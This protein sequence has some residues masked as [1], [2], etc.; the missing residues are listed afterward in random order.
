MS[1]AGVSKRI[2]RRLRKRGT[3]FQALRQPAPEACRAVIPRAALLSGPST[4]LRMN[5]A[6]NLA[7]LRRLRLGELPHKLGHILEIAA[8]GMPKRLFIGGF[9]YHNVV[10]DRLPIKCQL[11]LESSLQSNLSLGFI[12]PAKLDESA[13][14]PLHLP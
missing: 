9:Q 12:E 3:D 11:E 6:R 8:V 10:L 4:G 2:A 5:A 7:L 1:S 14:G 13:A